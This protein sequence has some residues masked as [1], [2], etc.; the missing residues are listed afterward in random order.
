[1]KNALS[2][3]GI[4]AAGVNVVVQ[5]LKPTGTDC[6]SWGDRAA[7]GTAIITVTYSTDWLTPVGKAFGDDLNVSK[8]SRMRI[9]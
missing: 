4:D 6:G 1:M 3:T 7:G 9:E 2:D 8:T 5:C